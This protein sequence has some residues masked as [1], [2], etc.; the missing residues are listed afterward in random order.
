MGGIFGGEQGS[1][2][3]WNDAYIRNNLFCGKLTVKGTDGIKG[4][5]RGYMKS[6]NK[7]N[8]IE[9]NFYCKE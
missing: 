2:Q 9:N 1:I 5:T 4:G 3:A 7:C 8:Y 6:L